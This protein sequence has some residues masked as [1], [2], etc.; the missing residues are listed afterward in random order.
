MLLLV[1]GVMLVLGCLMEALAILILVVPVLLPVLIATGVDPVHFGVVA[2]VALSA[3]LVT[4]P[5]GL[6]MFLMC[7]L[8]DVSVEEFAL[9]SIPFFVCIGVAL[10]LLIFFPEIVLW[11]PN[12]L[13]G[14]QCG[15][16]SRAGQAFHFLPL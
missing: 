1:V 8:A 15:G 12:L 3:G 4:P 2:T 9:E 16:T 11:L 10:G 13:M 5:F 6:T 14:K 7:K